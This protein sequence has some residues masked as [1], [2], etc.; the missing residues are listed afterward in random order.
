MA[1]CIIFKKDLEKLSKKVMKEFYEC[2]H[3]KEM[4]SYPEVILKRKYYDSF[5]IKNYLLDKLKTLKNPQLEDE[6]HKNIKNLTSK[7]KDEY[8][9]PKLEDDNEYETPEL[10]DDNE[11]E[12][13]T[14]L[15]SKLKVDIKDETLENLYSKVK[16]VY[17]DETLEKATIKKFFSQLEAEIKD[18]TLDL[19]FIYHCLDQMKYKVKIDEQI[20]FEINE[21]FSYMKKAFINLYDVYH[22][23]YTYLED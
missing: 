19:D 16:T 17:E 14:N 5:I 2:S 18:E 1:S 10:E 7:L 6:F 21:D 23:D 20:D 9:T 3:D 12:N 15:L 13:V 22:Y 8:K 4:L 11:Y